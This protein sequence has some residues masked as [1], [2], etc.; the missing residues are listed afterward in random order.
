MEDLSK[1]FSE[2]LKALRGEKSQ[3][4]FAK[5]LGISNS[6]TY[7]RYEAGRIPKMEILK[8]L[9][10][11]LGIDVNELFGKPSLPLASL[12][13]TPAMYISNDKDRILREVF[14]ILIQKDSP[15]QLANILQAVL[16]ADNLDDH[17]R[18]VVAQTITE[19]LQEKLKKAK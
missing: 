3:A 14:E 11:K 15:E 18:N 1:K 17:M 10:D 5:E 4:D 2:R 19:K 12:K 16:A 7:H 9:A 6:V 13:E 8:S